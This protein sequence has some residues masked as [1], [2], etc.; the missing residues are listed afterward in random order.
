MRKAGQ[1]ASPRFTLLTIASLLAG[2]VAFAENIDPNNDGSKYAWAE[3]MG[4]INLRPGGPGGEG[5]GPGL[6]GWAWSENAGWVSF[7]CTNRSCAGGSYGVT[8]NG[9]GTL[10]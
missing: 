3:N 6:A 5:P 8:N 7:S 9:C 2:G 4:W 1:R 10:A